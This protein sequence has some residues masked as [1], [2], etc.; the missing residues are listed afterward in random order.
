[1]LVKV[2]NRNQKNFGT[3]SN[4]DYIK[5]V[6]SARTGSS[7]RSSV[8]TGAGSKVETGSD[9]ERLDEDLVSISAAQS[10]DIEPSLNE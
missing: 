5:R 7:A 4:E 6:L 9:S 2:S 1:M 8:S 3:F 10:K